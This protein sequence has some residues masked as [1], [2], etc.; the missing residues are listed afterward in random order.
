MY[1]CCFSSREVSKRSEERGRD[2][3]SSCDTDVGVA[4][5]TTDGEEV[6]VAGFDIATDVVGVP[7]SLTILDGGR[8]CCCCC[9][10]EEICHPLVL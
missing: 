3:S 10:R 8:A 6:K 5:V 4:V 7:V 1:S 2:A 9:D